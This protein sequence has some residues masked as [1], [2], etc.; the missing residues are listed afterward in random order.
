[1]ERQK[2]EGAGK[3]ELKEARRQEWKRIERW[4]LKGK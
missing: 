3:A 1:V 2:L 4:E